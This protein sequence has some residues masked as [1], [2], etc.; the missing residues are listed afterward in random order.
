MTDY[1]RDDVA[2]MA[3]KLGF[4]V[5][6]EDLVDITFRI[7]QILGDLES[8]SDPRLGEVDSAPFLPFEGVTCE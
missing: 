8:F 7:N 2:A 1:T 4:T 6:D 5:T 3:E